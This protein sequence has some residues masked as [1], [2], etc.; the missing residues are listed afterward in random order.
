MLEHRIPPP[1]VAALIAAAMWGVST[2]PPSLPLAPVVTQLAAA[3]LAVLGFGFD[4]LGAAAF[5]RSKTTFSALHPGKA[6]ALVT[7][8][9]YRVT[10][11]P[12]YL[13]LALVLT[14]W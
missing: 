14:A 12:M 5:L 7:A 9:V 1:V 2:L 4:L 6:S 11:N 13:G 10:R 3:A 8:G